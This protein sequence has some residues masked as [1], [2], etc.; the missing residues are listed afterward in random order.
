MDPYLEG[1]YKGHVMAKSNNQK[2]KI[3]YLEHYLR[4]TGENRVVTM[5]DI[6]AYLLEK[7]IHAERK[8]IYDDL[9]VLRS[10]GMD[11]RYRRGKPGGYYL[12]S[13]PDSEMGLPLTRIIDRQAEPGPD[14]LLEEEDRPEAGKQAVQEDPPLAE[15]VPSPA[16]GDLKPTAKVIF[17]SG[18]EYRQ[19]RLLC[20]EQAYEQIR[21]FFGD[22]TEIRQKEGDNLVVTANA[23][24]TPI[25][26]GWL[27][28]M[29]VDVRLIKPKKMVQSYREYLKTLSR[30]Y[31]MS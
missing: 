24:D 29:G 23:P 21:A 25:F 6:L 19:V 13:D 12:V 5:Q 17:G 18:E 16:E 14:W 3:L 26:Y 1:I 15:P 31:K 27:T 10:F 20:S 8:S 22:E 9:E 2:G 30:E 4:G 28:A 7:D 11:I